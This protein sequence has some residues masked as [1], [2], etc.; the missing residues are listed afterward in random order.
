MTLVTWYNTFVVGWERSLLGHGRRRVLAVTE[1]PPVGVRLRREV[2]ARTD[3]AGA[4]KTRQ[5]GWQPEGVFGIPQW[6]RRK[7]P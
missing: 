7:N 2:I 4:T 1:K 5:S 3:S 6:S